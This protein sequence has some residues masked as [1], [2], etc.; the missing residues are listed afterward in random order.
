MKINKKSILLLLVFTFGILFFS[1]NSNRT[2]E[3]PVVDCSQPGQQPLSIAGE[4][5]KYHVTS[6]V[7]QNL[8]VSVLEDQLKWNDNDVYE[9]KRPTVPQSHYFKNL[10]IANF[11]LPHV[12][13]EIIGGKTANYSAM[14]TKGDGHYFEHV[15]W[16]G[17]CCF[18]II[19]Y[20]TFTIDLG[21]DWK[22]NYQLMGYNLDFSVAWSIGDDNPA[23]SWS[24]IEAYLKDTIPFPQEGWMTVGSSENIL[25]VNGWTDTSIQ[26]T[27]YPSYS[28]SSTHLLNCLVDENGVMRIRFVERTFDNRWFNVPQ[29]Y[30]GWDY[31]NL[32]LSCLDFNDEPCKI[33][34]LFE[35]AI[36]DGNL[37]YNIYFEGTP[38]RDIYRYS[39]F[40]ILINGQWA[41]TTSEYQWSYVLTDVPLETIEVDLRPNGHGTNYAEFDYFYI[42]QV[43]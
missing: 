28:S 19:A 16:G 38:E 37:L 8:E 4:S 29:M 2:F 40:D 7:A 6:A 11:D 41:L 20:Q 36:L 39:S 14:Q 5:Q 33:E 18:E 24:W 12:N 22:S 10:T 1:V 34:F 30:F 43:T 42:R 35:D 17:W 13:Q 31:W 32:T 15:Y 26:S 27:D 3:S 9:I 25:N 23:Y 21:P